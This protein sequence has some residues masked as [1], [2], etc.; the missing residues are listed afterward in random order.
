MPGNRSAD[1]AVA[2]YSLIATGYLGVIL[3]GDPAGVAQRLIRIGKDGVAKDTS[4][5]RDPAM[6]IMVTGKVKSLTASARRRYMVVIT[7][8]IDQDQKEVEIEASMALA[9]VYM[10]GSLITLTLNL[11]E[12][13]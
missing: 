9:A 3:P 7:I 11:G 10:P 12:A 1:D 4:T 6:N 13:K 5:E 2:I 8:V